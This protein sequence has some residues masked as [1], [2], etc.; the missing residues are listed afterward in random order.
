VFF[1]KI[2][3]TYSAKP[4][5]FPIFITLYQQLISLICVIILGIIGQ[6]LN[7][8]YA[9]IPPLE[10]K[11]ETAKAVLPLTLIYVAMLATNN[12]SLLSVEI[13]YFQI[14]RSLAVVFQ[15]IF[16]YT[17]LGV[18]TSCRAIQSCIL[19]VV[20]FIVGSGGE[21]RFSWVGAI[22]G[23][24]SSV[25]VAL[26]GIFVKKTLPSVEDN[27]WKLLMYNLIMSIGLL[28]PLIF[29]YGEWKEIYEFDFSDT[30]TQWILVSVTGLFGFL[31]NVA[32]FLQ[33]KYTSPLTSV[34]VGVWL[35]RIFKGSRFHLQ[36]SNV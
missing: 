20:G 4:F 16:T 27:E 21:I 34:I 13:S 1:N 35:L 31:I 10:F 9:L 7:P 8:Q 14:A 5:E 2:I 3:F 36:I 29:A 26:N 15:L 18:S 33:I 25:F 23:V 12:L 19:V 24:V 32:L 17:I 22:Y 30:M 11:L 6:W 28:I